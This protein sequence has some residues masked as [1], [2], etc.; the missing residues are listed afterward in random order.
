MLASGDMER[1]GLPDFDSPQGDFNLLGGDFDLLCGDFDLLR[2]DFEL[3]R[4]VF[5]LSSSGTSRFS[6]EI[7]ISF[8]ETA[9]TL[10]KT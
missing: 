5:D 7:S 4:E 6:V 2:G 10:L 9:T 1:T 3:V 8:V